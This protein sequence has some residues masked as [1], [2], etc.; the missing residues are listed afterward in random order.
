M[1]A[2]TKDERI[3]RLQGQKQRLLEKMQVLRTNPHVRNAEH[4]LALLND[5]VTR[6][7]DK[8]VELKARHD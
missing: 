1:R 3:K 4:K 2:E 6:I 8:I 7:T 5:Q